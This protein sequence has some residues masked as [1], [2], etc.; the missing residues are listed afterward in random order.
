MNNGQLSVIKEEDEGENVENDQK[1]K[2]E[3]SNYLSGRIPY[4]LYHTQAKPGPSPTEMC[5]PEQTKRNIPIDGLK[6][7][8]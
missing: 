1:K 6:M 2:P 4:Y 8:Y 7:F 5:S 3:P